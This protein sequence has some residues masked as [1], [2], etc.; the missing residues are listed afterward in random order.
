MTLRLFDISLISVMSNYIHKYNVDKIKAFLISL[1]L[2]STLLGVLFYSSSSEPTKEAQSL[3]ETKISVSL[4]GVPKLVEVA[5][6]VT[7]PSP[8]KPLIKQPVAAKKV[9]KPK[10]TSK[11]IAKKNVVKK[12]SVEQKSLLPQEPLKPAEP[13]PQ[14]TPVEETLQK[15][16]TKTA[17]RPRQEAPT[18]VTKQTQEVQKTQPPQE[19]EI[20]QSQLSQIRS[21]IQNSLVYPPMARRLKIE[22][23]VVVSFVLSADGKVQSANILSRSGNTSLDKKALQTVLALSGEYPQLHRKIDLKIPIS[24]SLKNS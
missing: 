4:M 18:Q 3:K 5:K 1:V 7:K 10:P 22:G 13:L 23:T 14:Q 8:I 24:F 2:H 15:T 20:S 12:K 17:E 9:A 19:E 6:P 11:T 21:L 16:P